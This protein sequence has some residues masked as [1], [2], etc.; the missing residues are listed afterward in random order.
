[1]RT[2]GKGLD[3]AR[4]ALAMAEGQDAGG[5]LAYAGNMRIQ[6]GDGPLQFLRSQGRGRM[7]G[8]GA[9]TPVDTTDFPLA[10][11]ARTEFVEQVEGA[12]L[13]GRVPFQR[14]PFNVHLVDLTDGGQA[15]WVNESALKPATALQFNPVG[16]LEPDKVSAIVG[17]TDELR[18]AA[19]P[20]LDAIFNNALINA[21]ASRL[22]ASF[23]DPANAGGK[24]EPASITYSAPKIA[25]TGDLVADMAAALGMLAHPSRAVFLANS[26]DAVKMAALR[27]PN[28]DY[29]FNDVGAAGGSALRT[30]L[31]TSDATPPGVIVACD[32][33]QVYVATDGPLLDEA[34]YATIDYGDGKPVS[35]WAANCFAWRIEFYANWLAAGP[36]SVA[37]ITGALVGG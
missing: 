5:A 23:I 34:T 2:N 4:A 15:A 21:S 9:V 27:A 37:T 14:A 29:L 13:L 17:F 16:R 10:A 25:A 35:L 6:W 26:H 8:K 36:D 28:G 18:R 30:P 11:Q 24:G 7:R 1:M 33:S 19:L 3:V 22:D 20:S 32:P 12:T 31:Y